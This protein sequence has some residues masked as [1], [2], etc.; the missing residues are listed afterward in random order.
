MA[1]IGYDELRNLRAKHARER[2][3]FCSGSFD[4]PHIGH[5]R[6]LE[7]CKEEGDILLV[8]VGKDE[9]IKKDKGVNRPVVGESARVRLIHAMKPVDY[10]FISRSPNP[11][12]A[13]LSPIEEIFMHILPDI[14]IVNYDGAKL[15]ERQQIAK[16][17]GVP[18]KIFELRREGERE[19]EWTSTTG[20]IKKIKEG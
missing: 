18:I 12:E 16:R 5:L 2:I 8:A 14:W 1:I 11:P 3:V 9:D 13:W 7:A 17:H 15:D 10:A 6:F 19:E 4:I 20:L